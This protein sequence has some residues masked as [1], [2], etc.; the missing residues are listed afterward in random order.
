MIIRAIHKTHWEQRPKYDYVALS[1]DMGKSSGMSI[2]FVKDDVIVDVE[3]YHITFSKDDTYLYFHKGLKP[4]IEELGAMVDYMIY[5]FSIFDKK[6]LTKVGKG[7]KNPWMVQMKTIKSI[8]KREGYVEDFARLNK[9][10]CL[11][12]SPLNIMSLLKRNTTAM[13]E[14]RFIDRDQKKKFSIELLSNYYEGFDDVFRSNASKSGFVNFADDIADSF[15]NGWSAL[16]KEKGVIL[17]CEK[18]G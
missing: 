5:E 10:T 8:A 16:E 6:K 15:S 12:S 2:L 4:I 1:F 9:V 14:H 11:E 3:L 13:M 7:L 18:F 17:D